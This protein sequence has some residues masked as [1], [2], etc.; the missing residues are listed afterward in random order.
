MNNIDEYINGSGEYAEVLR[1]VRQHLCSVFSMEYGAISFYKFNPNNRTAWA[2]VF[3]INPGIIEMNFPSDNKIRETVLR[4][5]NADRDYKEFYYYNQFSEK[6]TKKEHFDIELTSKNDQLEHSLTTIE[7]KNWLDFAN[8]LNRKNILDQLF[9]KSNESKYKVIPLP[10]LYSPATLIVVPKDAVASAEKIDEIVTPVAESVHF[11]L[12]NRLLTEI[13]KDLKPGQIK[14]KQE[15]IQQFLKQLVEVA[16][17]IKY[18]FNEIEYKCFEWYGS[19]NT[20]SSAIIELTL[21]GEIVKMY[22][23]TFCWHDGKMLHEKE[24][25]VVREKQVKKTIENIF[26]LIHSNWEAVN[27]TKRHGRHVLKQIVEDSGLNLNSLESFSKEMDKIKNAVECAVNISDEEYANKLGTVASK[28]VRLQKIYEQGK[29]TGYKVIYG[30]R[31]IVCYKYNK[32]ANGKLIRHF[33]YDVL[34][35]I[36]QANG[37]TINAIEFSFFEEVRGELPYKTP[38]IE[39]QNVIK[40]VSGVVDNH[41]DEL[42]YDNTAGTSSKS[43]DKYYAITE[44]NDINVLKEWLEKAGITIPSLNTMRFNE[45]ETKV[46]NLEFIKLWVSEHKKNIDQIKQN[47]IDTPGLA[48]ASTY[49]NTLH[50]YFADNI[51]GYKNW[52]KYKGTTDIAKVLRGNKPT[53]NVQNSDVTQRIAQNLN[54]LCTRLINLQEYGTIFKNNFS[55]AELD[56]NQSNRNFKYNKTKINVANTL[57]WIFD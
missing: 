51:D 45:F 39:N 36:I 5:I 53:T 1:I 40:G 26:K 23:P 38:I 29:E 34:R 12:F 30:Q 10:I 49:I 14:D 28:E 54:Q 4:F 8:D 13:T 17:P 31:E 25:Y 48:H 52:H 20:D 43:D 55:Q 6:Y 37:K 7:N 21:A 16:I 42:A 19:W 46:T 35:E 32:R 22:M 3:P 18:E 57:E 41:E 50:R 33:G 24:E 27:D 44:V 56:Y 15:L 47:N 11:Y 9:Y 2:K